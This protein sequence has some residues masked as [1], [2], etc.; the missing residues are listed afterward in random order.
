MGARE[1]VAG[2]RMGAVAFDWHLDEFERIRKSEGVVELLREIGE[3]IVSSL[4]SE[5][6]AAQQAR[7][8]TV[9]DGYKFYVTNGGEASRAR[10]HVLAFT[11]RA[12]AH[13]AAHQSILR[14]LGEA[15]ASVQAGRTAERALA[16]AQRDAARRARNERL[17]REAGEH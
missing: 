15:T 6:H 5:L 1:S 9:E 16:R 12:M 14:K 10:L 3:E 4:N 13:E 7:D 11:A 2:Q 8:Q 17:Q